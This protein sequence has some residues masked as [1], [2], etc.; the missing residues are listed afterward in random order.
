MAPNSPLHKI[1]RTAR[2]LIGLHLDYPR[3]VA[4][5]YAMLVVLIVIGGFQ[6]FQANTNRRLL[7]GVE[8]NGANHAFDSVSTADA[9]AEDFTEDSSA[10]ESSRQQAEIDLALYVGQA[11]TP[12][13]RRYASVLTYYLDAVA[14]LPVI[15]LKCA[16]LKL[17]A[18][19]AEAA[20]LEQTLDHPYS[21]S[22]L[23][24]AEVTY[25]ACVSARQRVQSQTSACHDEAL[26]YIAPSR[27]PPVDT[28]AFRH[29]ENIVVR[30]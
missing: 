8:L 6:F 28:C 18:H 30:K 24:R 22:A 26:S 23:V 25:S 15:D 2:Y 3:I 13:G 12:E 29:S 17:A 20:Y 11:H 1:E 21:K 5:I 7:R 16:D 10:R 27:Q 19:S 9:L 14:D 4:A